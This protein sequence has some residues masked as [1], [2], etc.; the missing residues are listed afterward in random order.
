MKQNY[1]VILV[2][3][4]VAGCAAAIEFAK[5]GQSVLL[6]DQA[7]FP[8]DTLSTHFMNPR[9]MTYLK[10]L[11]VLEEVLATTPAFGFLEVAIDGFALGGTVD[12]EALRSRFNKIHG[13]RKFELENRYACIRRT[14]LD[15]TLQKKAVE[16]GV[17]LI[18]GFKVADLIS[19]NGRVVAVVGADQAGQ[20]HRFDAKLIVGADGR[21]SS[22]ARLL[23]VEKHEE[24]NACTF[25]CY[26]YFS[27]LD[28]PHGKL[29]R[30]HRTAYAAIPTND[31]L[32]MVLVYELSHF[33]QD[34]KKNKESHFHGAIQNID[35]DFH[36]H[37]S[38]KGR[39][40]E[41][42]YATDD[43]AAFMRKASP[44]GY[45]SWVMR[46]SSRISVPPAE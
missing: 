29:K 26:T 39:Q 15:N 7:R 34:F 22:V 13:T 3:A 12:P 37:L 45:R 2:G 27:G 17:D 25:A 24:K 28:L 14:F 23:G 20:K 6:L 16:S 21:R 11:G 38:E 10:A 4:R 46:H 9:G 35:P 1:D 31:G 42:F 32:T 19:E 36:A 18:T 8:S 41:P 40:V 5:R 30:L 33:F 44:R 43:Q